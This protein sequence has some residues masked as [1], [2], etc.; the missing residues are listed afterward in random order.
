MEAFIRI[1]RDDYGI[2]T[3][4]PEQITD[5]MVEDCLDLSP[6]IIEE[7][8]DRLLN[9]P[10]D[11]GLKPM[12]HCVEVL[13]EL[14]RVAAL[15]FITA[16]PAKDPVAHWLEKNFG[17][18]IFAKTRLIATGEHDTKGFYIKEL[19]LKYFVDDRAQTC[20]DLALDNI[21]PIVYSQPWNRGRHNLASVDNWPA[22]RQLCQS[23]QPISL[24]VETRAS[25]GLPA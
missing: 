4:L 14:S 17:A 22:I 10:V 21:V 1:A 7:I 6:Y 18:E 3:I 13:T 11:A 15:T 25:R 2:T 9:N 16:R 20:M 5:F 12:A 23:P 19:G 24:H 8:F